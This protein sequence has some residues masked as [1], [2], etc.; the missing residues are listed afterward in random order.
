MNMTNPTAQPYLGLLRN[1]ID[2]TQVPFSDRGSRILI[3]QYPEDHQL[4]IK[5]AERILG[6]DPGLAA[7]RERPPFIDH[8]SFIDEHGQELDFTLVTSPDVLYFQ[9]E[10]G[11]FGM[12]FQ[13]TRTIS[14]HPPED[15]V[16]GL[17]FRVLADF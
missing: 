14:V 17:R 10:V 3:Y 2:I 11:E 8:L 6:L 9:T 13:D 1:Q 16:A 12:V 5:L 7:Y 15:Q 4:L